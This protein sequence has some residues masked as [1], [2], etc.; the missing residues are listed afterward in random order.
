MHKEW[1]RGKD[2]GIHECVGSVKT[3]LAATQFCEQQAQGLFR[4]NPGVQLSTALLSCAQH[5]SL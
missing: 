1:V 4:M 5:F 2:G 3:V